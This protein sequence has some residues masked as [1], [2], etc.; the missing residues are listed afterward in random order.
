MAT[1][2]TID[3]GKVET[4][5]LRSAPP[6]DPNRRMEALFFISAKDCN[7][8]GDPDEANRPRQDPE[9]GH[10]LITGVSVKR[11]I[12]D[13]AAILMGN[14]PGYA[15]Y[16]SRKAILDYKLLAIH[17]Q[18]GIKQ[19][20]KK[21]SKKGKKGEELQ[22]EEDEA[23]GKISEEDQ[24]RAQE[25]ACKLYF[26]NRVFGAVMSSK[27]ANCGQ[28]R[29]P[30]QVEMSRSIDPVLIS[31]DSITRGSIQTER[32]AETNDRHSTFGDRQRVAF[33]LYRG[34][35]YFSP[36]FAKDTNLSGEDL[37]L[38][39]ESLCR[40]H[41]YTRSSA[42]AGIALEQI[43]VFEHESFLG[44]APAHKLLRMVDVKAKDANK[45]SRSV[46]D[47][48]FPDQNEVQSRIDAA[49]YKNVKVHFLL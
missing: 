23:T 16:I 25:L 2:I 24:K 9:T 15:L 20:K 27:M 12:R 19:V 43:V 48:S 30:F 33:G 28:L 44:N 31:D 49:G 42:R 47:Y 6:T 29:G 26:D 17:E 46:D 36:C 18:L 22:A 39:W 13:T 21:A 14:T 37:K 5:F 7:P 8:N 45:P 11:H 3:G 32:E 34:E 10:G 40:M 38:F 1:Q 35:I 41:E 4:S